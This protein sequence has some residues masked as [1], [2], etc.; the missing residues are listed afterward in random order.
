MV[1]AFMDDEEAHLEAM[2]SFIVANGLD[3]EL[4]R[5]DW[6][7]FARGYNGASYHV[8]GDHTRLERA[9]SKW[10]GTRDT[11]YTRVA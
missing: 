1:H 2:V 8:H 11:P 3:D 5:H 4:R 7:G 9:F 10:A 6:R